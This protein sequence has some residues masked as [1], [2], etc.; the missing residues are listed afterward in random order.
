MDAVVEKR[1]GILRSVVTVMLVAALVSFGLGIGCTEVAADELSSESFGSALGRF[2][3]IKAGDIDNDSKV[4]IVFGNMEGFLY[5][6]EADT[7]NN[8]KKDWQ[9][10]YI[11][12]RLWGTELGDVDGDGVV[13]IVT[14][15]W[16]GYTYVYDGIT[17]KRQ[18]RSDKMK[19]DAHGTYIA[20][21]DLDGDAEI[22]VGTGYRIDAGSAHV[23][24]GANGTEEWH[25]GIIKKGSYTAH[26]FRGVDVEDVDLDGTPEIL[27]GFATRQGETEGEGYFRIY[28]GIDYTLEYESPDLKGDCEAIEVIDVDSDGELEIVCVAGYRLRP[29]WIY[30]FDADTRELEWKSP[31]YGP[32]PYGLGVA[33]V[34]SD[35]IIEIVSSNQAG[36]VRVINGIS[37]EVEWKSDILGSDALG[38]ELEDV[39][40][41]GTVDIIV[42][43]GGYRGKSGYSS[44]YSQGYIYIFD[45]ETHKLLWKVGEIDWVVLGY[46]VAALIT[47]VVVLILLNRYLKYRRTVHHITTTTTSRMGSAEQLSV[48]LKTIKRTNGI[49]FKR[50]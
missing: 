17:K 35:G 14:G 15:G 27:I 28:D 16:D 22:V 31:D 6:I 45:G 19:S 30:V 40:Q 36:I 42:G 25:S 20:D 38:I 4:E 13:E 18:W 41:D 34:D 46:Q 32:K 29:G 8:F 12:T 7:E 37:H 23:L 10:G 50:K 3:S 26:S 49:K 43:V 11:D 21:S 33:D 39:N 1:K 9:S 48:R 5:V 24:S 47:I 2:N 44:S